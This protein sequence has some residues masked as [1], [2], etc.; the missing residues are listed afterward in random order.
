MCVKGFTRECLI[1]EFLYSGLRFIG[2]KRQENLRSSSKQFVFCNYFITSLFW[3][4]EFIIFLITF[5]RGQS[6]KHAQKMKLSES[7][8]WTNVE[9]VEPRICI[10][11]GMSFFN[12]A[13]NLCVVI[14]DGEICIVSYANFVIFFVVFLGVFNC[15][16]PRYLRQILLLYQLRNKQLIISQ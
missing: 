7:L 4:N 9:I 5:K 2:W 1:T 11:A 3:R 8:L 10:S 12:N 16:I 15:W 6:L 13:T 14:R